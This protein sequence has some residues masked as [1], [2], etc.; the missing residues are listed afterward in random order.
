MQSAKSAQLSALNL[1]FPWE[2]KALSMIAL[3]AIML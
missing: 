3:D 1:G 2:K